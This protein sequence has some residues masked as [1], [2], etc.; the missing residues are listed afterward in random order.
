MPPKRIPIKG[1]PDFTVISDEKLKGLIGLCQQMIYSYKGVDEEKVRVF[2]EVWKQLSD[3]ST[4]RLCQSACEELSKEEE[5]PITIM[6]KIKK[7]K[8]VKRIKR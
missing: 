7:V 5:T 6:H 4:N 3:E 8:P 2:T 1:E